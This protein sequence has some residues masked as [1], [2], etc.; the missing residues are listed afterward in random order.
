LAIARTL[1]VTVATVAKWR[2]RFITGGLVALLDGK[3]ARPSRQ[4]P[5][6]KQHQILAL[7]ASRALS[8]RALACLAGV[9]QSTVIRV[10]RSAPDR[11]A[12][13]RSQRQRLRGS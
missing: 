11:G 10:L 5:G 8:S 6:S 7:A 12:A 3:H 2:R 9:S 4:L 1:R 13:A